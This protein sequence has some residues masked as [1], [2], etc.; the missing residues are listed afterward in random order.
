MY[1]VIYTHSNQTDLTKA[2]VLP[3]LYKTFK[4]L[5]SALKCAYK[6]NEMIRQQVLGITYFVYDKNNHEI[7]RAEAA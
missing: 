3:Y 7:L 2:D 1:A 4:S 5:K 6:R